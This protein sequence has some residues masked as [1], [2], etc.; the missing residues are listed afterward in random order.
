MTVAFAP[1]NS[2]G[3][4]PS[5]PSGTIVTPDGYIATCAH[6][7]LA[8][9]ADVTV[10][11]AD[12]RTVPAKLLGR[13]DFLDIGLAKITAPGPWPFATMGK[14][15]D[16]KVGDV[17]VFAGYPGYLRKKGK[18]PLVV[19]GARVADTQYV[20]AE[21]LILCQ[22]WDGDSGGGLFDVKGRLI[23]VHSGPATPRKVRAEAG[24][25][26]FATLWGSLVKGPAFNDPVSF[27]ASPT[28]AAVRRAIAESS[29]DCLR[30]SRR[31]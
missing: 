28:A 15:T 10:F 4:P 1:F 29:A 23:G 20:P 3:Q 26:G 13:D 22:T 2:P 21:L 31:R 19:R 8:R 9:G 30:G 11:F 25:D 24:A 27:E 12:G 18:V 17:C 7:K 5:G 16:M 14:T 6:G